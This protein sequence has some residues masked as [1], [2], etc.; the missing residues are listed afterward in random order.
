MVA[1][2]LSPHAGVK[3]AEGISGGHQDVPAV[4]CRTETVESLQ[5]RL[6]H[7]PQCFGVKN[8]NTCIVGQ[9]QPRGWRL[10]LFC[11]AAFG[12]GTAGRIGVCRW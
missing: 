8:R 2:R 1:M 7:C 5:G 3:D 11:L 10:G 9:D 6:P 12:G 4:A